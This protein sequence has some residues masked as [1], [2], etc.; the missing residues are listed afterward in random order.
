MKNY[1]KPEIKIETI[2]INDVILVSSTDA[3]LDWND[4]SV[5]EE[6]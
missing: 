2:E 1:I 6:L 4:N 5:D 3:T